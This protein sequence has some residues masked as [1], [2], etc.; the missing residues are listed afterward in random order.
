MMLPLH[1]LA[2]ELNRERL[3]L[4]ELRRPARRKR[5]WRNALW[6]AQRKARLM[7][8]GAVR[9]VSDRPTTGC[10]QANERIAHNAYCQSQLKSEHATDPA[11]RG[12]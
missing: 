2:D 4:A 8:V 6:S 7:A 11:A 12:H 3:A 1:Q 9:V 5:S 10:F